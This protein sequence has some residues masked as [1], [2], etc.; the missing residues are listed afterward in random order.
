MDRAS[1]KASK[2]GPYAQAELACRSNWKE[3]RRPLSKLRIHQSVPHKFTHCRVPWG[4][5]FY[6]YSPNRNLLDE[7]MELLGSRKV[8]FKSL[9]NQGFYHV[10]TTEM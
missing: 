9:C 2:L 6:L 7:L 4:S 10:T 3:H 1:Q 8:G 5:N